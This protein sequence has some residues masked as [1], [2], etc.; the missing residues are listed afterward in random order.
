MRVSGN[1]RNRARIVMFHLNVTTS[2]VRRFCSSPLGAR[3]L[4]GPGKLAGFGAPFLLLRR[5][6]GDLPTEVRAAYL[7]GRKAEIRDY[8]RFVPTA[9]LSPNSQ[10][11][12]AARVLPQQGR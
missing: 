5:L 6:M 7:A 11:Q 12:S 8:N 3:H 1:K 10:Q 4:T 2:K 9:Q